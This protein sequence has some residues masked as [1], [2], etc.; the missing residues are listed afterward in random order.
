MAH[1]TEQYQDRTAA[2]ATRDRE[3][4]PA[5]ARREAI[6]LDD[7]LLTSVPAL[8]AIAEPVYLAQSAAEREAVYAFRYD[9]YVRELGYTI[10]SAEHDHEWIRD[11]EDLDPHAHLLYTL[12]ERGIVS[13]TARLMLWPAGETP[14]SVRDE[15]SVDVFPGLAGSALGEFSR[16]IIARGARG[17]NGLVSIA[18]AAYQLAARHELSALLQHCAP[19]LVPYYGGLGMAPYP[20]DLI[21]IEDGAF[22]PLVMFPFDRA[23]MEAT[24]SALSPLADL[25]TTSAPDMSACHEA[26]TAKPAPAVFNTDQVSARVAEHVETLGGSS[27]LGRLAPDALAALLE[28]AFLLRVPAGMRLTAAGVKQ[29]EVFVVLE[30]DALA[31]GSEGIET[32]GPGAFLCEEGQLRDDGIRQNA[33]WAHHDLTLLVIRPGGTRRLAAQHPAQADLLK[34]ILADGCLACTVAAGDGEVR[35]QRQ[36]S[37]R[38]GRIT[39]LPRPHLKGVARLQFHQPNSFPDATQSSVRK[40]S[41]TVSIR[42]SLTLALLALTLIPASASASGLSI[43]TVASPAEGS[44]SGLQ[45]VSCVSPTSCITIGNT[46]T[47]GEAAGSEPF[48]DGWGGT[49]WAPIQAPALVTGK[50]DLTAISCASSTFCAAVG[51]LDTS[52]NETVVAASWN[53]DEWSLMT[54]PS[55]SGQL[56]GVSCVSTTFCVAVGSAQSG[57]PLVERWNGSNWTTVSTTRLPAPHYGDLRGVSCVSETSCVA[58]GE[59][60]ALNENAAAAPGALVERWNGKDWTFEHANPRPIQHNSTLTGVSCTSASSCVAVGAFFPEEG[61]GYPGKQLAEYWNG[62]DWTIA[63]SATVSR[64]GGDLEAVSCISTTSCTAVGV[65]NPGAYPLHDNRISFHWKNAAL[66]EHWNGSR[67]AIEPVQEPHVESQ[68]EPWLSGVS[69]VAPD[70]CTAVGKTAAGS[71]TAPL[72]E[73]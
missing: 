45:A 29:R 4:R 49:A 38:R 54:Q 58:V 20:G 21:E 40:G 25:A 3:T 5:E 64:A 65:L 62:R 48:A 28:D 41:R 12:D 42:R 32:R 53:G 18:L 34:A 24:G 67:W 35:W 27:C 51:S 43:Q 56:L 26:A 23:W 30:G 7:E 72:A 69:C 13:G 55:V 36:P 22:V 61:N 1:N 47:T 2:C 31:V 73:G 52:G 11:D 66:A 9:V 33:V 44:S 37:R 10:G 50:S 14:G 15:Y 6:V 8:A 19:G 71:L 59:Y 46:E 70:F 17:A 68:S 57:R 39:K 63:H 60:Q 16:L